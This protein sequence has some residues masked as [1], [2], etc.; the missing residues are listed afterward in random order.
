MSR[1]GLTALPNLPTL[2]VVD[3]TLSFQHKGDGAIVVDVYL[4]DGTEAAGGD[5][6]AMMA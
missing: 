6:E 3:R 1:K 5:G 2:R 4:H